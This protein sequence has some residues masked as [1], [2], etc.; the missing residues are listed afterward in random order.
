M[1]LQYVL[2]T[3]LIGCIGARLLL[4]FIAKQVNKKWLRVMGY[5]ALLP[6][7]GFMYIFLTG[8]RQTGI[9][10]AG[11]KIW[12]NG[13]R[14]LHAFMYSLFAYFAITGN[15]DAWIYLFADAMIGLFAFLWFHSKN[16]DFSKA[17]L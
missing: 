2:I 7:F 9:E 16:G 5:V 8:S 13:M 6:V 14:P 12:W 1:E 3:F 4:A 11:G 10:A 15:R 17:F